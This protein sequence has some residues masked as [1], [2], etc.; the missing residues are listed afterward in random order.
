MTSPAA[1]AGLLVMLIATV[2]VG[3]FAR[4]FAHTTSD[5]LVAARAVRPAAN[6]AAIS[7]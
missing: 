7:G 3:V 5:F 4:R 1:V 2:A 6:A